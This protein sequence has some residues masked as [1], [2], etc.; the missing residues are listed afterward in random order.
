MT[1]LVP[2]FLGVVAT[3]SLYSAGGGI[4]SSLD[5][6]TLIDVPAPTLRV[7]VTLVALFRASPVP[8]SVPEPELSDDSTEDGDPNT[9]T[10]PPPD[11]GDVHFGYD[12]GGGL[13]ILLPS[14][15]FCPLGLEQPTIPDPG[16][17]YYSGGTCIV[18]RAIPSGST[19]HMDI[20]DLDPVVAYFSITILAFSPCASEIGIC[21][22]TR[23][24][25][26]ADT[27]V[28]GGVPMGVPSFYDIQTFSFD[29]ILM[30]CQVV[31][32]D[33]HVAGPDFLPGDSPAID[34]SMTIDDTS[35]RWTKVDSGGQDATSAYGGT[36]FAV[37]IAD[38]SVIDPTQPA[39]TFEI[40]DGIGNNADASG[41]PFAGLQIF[42]LFA[43]EAF[44][45]VLL[46]NGYYLKQKP[47]VDGNPPAA[48]DA[49][50]TAAEGI[51][52]AL[53]NDTLE[54]GQTWTRLDG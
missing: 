16:G 34:A 46:R 40:S 7:P 39:V 18:S 21:M 26:P 41:G 19:I 53:P 8:G 31:A 45:D 54:M 24:I 15:D 12:H 1:D 51:V 49:D 13:T 9:W 2:N 47:L 14:S 50:P 17:C 27:N 52:V 32:C 4:P 36:I 42:G 48:D 5:M 35:G 6:T 29:Q 43:W 22:T 30:I 38:E 10:I 44:F 23:S 20:A 37:F 28:L 33:S 11:G 3:G 25:D